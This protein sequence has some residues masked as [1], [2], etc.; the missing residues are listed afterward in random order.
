[1]ENKSPILTF[2]F[3][4]FENLDYVCILYGHIYLV[5]LHF[6]NLWHK[7]ASIT[8]TTSDRH[9]FCGLCTGFFFSKWS[10][11]IWT[12]FLLRLQQFY[13]RAEEATQKC[14]CC[15]YNMPL[16]LLHISLVNFTKGSLLCF[17]CCKSDSYSI[18]YWVYFSD[19][20]KS[21]YHTKTLW[22]C[23]QSSQRQHDS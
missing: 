15:L 4:P 22:L 13:K 7:S 11:C 12:G 3:F 5:F 2:F 18:I 20:L 1:M 10:N 8:C 19:S 14:L 16:F 9:C 17:D 6:Y 23:W 21:S